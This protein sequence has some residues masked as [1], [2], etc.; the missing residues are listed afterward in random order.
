MKTLF[1]PW[2]GSNWPMN[3]SHGKPSHAPQCSTRPFAQA[4]SL[5]LP[6]KG[7]PFWLP[8]P[9]QFGFSFR[10]RKLHVPQYVPH[11]ATRF[12]SIDLPQ[13]SSIGAIIISLGSGWDF[14]SVCLT[15]LRMSRNDR[16]EH[17]YLGQPRKVVGQRRSLLRKSLRAYRK[18]I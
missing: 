1:C 17:S 14:V 2:A 16:Y 11:G 3:R 5:H 12:L 18:H 10:F 6:Q 8:H 15:E 9:E 13:A 4:Y 7:C